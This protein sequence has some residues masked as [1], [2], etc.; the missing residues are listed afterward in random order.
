MTREPPLCCASDSA[1]RERARSAALN[2]I[3]HVEVD[4]SQTELRVN[5]LGRAPEWIEPRYV[6]IEGGVRE[7]DI[8]V[9]G[10]RIERGEDEGLDDVMIVRVDRP[11]D[12]STYRLCIL[13][14]DA[15]GRPAEEAP[16]DFDPRYAC[17]AFSF[18]ASCPSDVDCAEPPDCPPQAFAE[19]D[20]DYLAKDY[21]SFR[22]LM[23]DRLSLT[24]P[25][26]C[27]RHSPDM[28]L[29]LV[30]LLAYVGD[31]LSYHQ[32]AVGAEAFLETARRRISVKRHARLVGYHLHEGCNARAW[33]VLDVSEPELSIDPADIVFITAWPGRPQPM[34]KAHELG[35]DLPGPSVAFEPLLPKGQ[36][37]LTLRSARNEIHFHDWDEEECCLP[38]GAT[39]ATLRD[40]GTIPPP[41]EGKDEKE[42][43]C[44][45]R[46]PP[47]DLRDEIGEGRWHRLGLSAGDVLVFEERVG[48][49]TGVAADADPSRRHAVRL[50]RADPSLDPLSG[51]LLW[52]VEW[53]VEDSLP[54]ALCL[55]SRRDPPNCDPL[56]DVSV[57]RGNVV[58]ADSGSSFD[59]DLGEVPTKRV[60]RRCEEDCEAAEERSVAG[61]Y[62]PRVRRL[63][64]T[65]AAPYA[66]AIPAEGGCRGASATAA[67]LQEP[68]RCLPAVTLTSR[69]ADGSGP[70]RIWRPV[71]DLLGSG[72]E[73]GHFV[74]EMDD[75]R[76]A[77]LRF[78]DGVNGRAPEAGESFRAAYRSGTGPGGNVAAGAIRQ[79]V[80]RNNYPD[81]AAIAVRNPLPAQGGTRPEEVARAKLRAPHRFHHRLERAIAPEDYAAI[82]MRDFPAQVQRAAAHIRSTGAAVEVHVAIDS[83]GGRPDPVLL[84]L[85]ETHLQAYRRIHHDVRAVPAEIVPL[86]I[87]LTVC[88][89]PAYLR[90]HVKAELQRV[91][92]AGS[93]ARGRGFFHPD[94]MSFGDRITLSRIA[95]AAHKVDGVASII[96]TRLERL[97]E[98]RNGEVESGELALGPFEVARLDN[99]PGQP[100]N[101]ALRLNLRGGR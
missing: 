85:I 4:C 60:D 33:I 18:K 84:R 86:L 12:F 62:R 59:D 95:A 54:F 41:E 36:S 32:D 71:R 83:Y 51:T 13:G 19:P 25:D 22:R 49:R 58:L 98:G 99:D 1:R 53:C 46:E 9:R 70:E 43:Y 15:Q 7:R 21:S 69:L 26:W 94:E 61:R 31:Q 72:G 57:V 14:R 79:I 47:P 64:P 44:P 28:M 34:L 2:G 37:R 91:L 55:S 38:A 68:D 92:G 30:E 42:C 89:R 39:R 101:G 23:L 20:I 40:P 35:R 76:V 78:G 50:T 16:A 56:R 73:D 10:L 8:K 93:W 24:L 90:G 11:G 74:V 97:R 81:G 100:E 77:W 96:V 3:D 80:F 48:P 27:E 17:A 63:D 75:E 45:G 82:V 5:F 29:T 67:L 52:E 88:V 65:F 87:E 6:R 66:P